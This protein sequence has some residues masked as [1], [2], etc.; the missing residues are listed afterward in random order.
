MS[1]WLPWPVTHTSCLSLSASPHARAGRALPA[2]LC[3]RLS[4]GAT[5]A[6]AIWRQTRSQLTGTLHP[7]IL[8]THRC[9]PP[10]RPPGRAPAYQPALRATG[11]R[12]CPA[13]WPTRAC[14]LVGTGLGCTRTSDGSH[15]GAG[16][17]SLTRLPPSSTCPALWR[18]PR[19]LPVA[20]PRRRP[21][22]R[23]CHVTEPAASPHARSSTHGHTPHDVP[24][25][26]RAV[27]WPRL[28]AAPLASCA[29]TRAT[30]RRRWPCLGPWRPFPRRRIAPPMVL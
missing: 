16:P 17:G 18:P 8:T 20:R 13:A 12:A 14:G 30:G 26:H 7:L 21:G 27:P 9:T 4:G 1:S 3:Y 22:R 11:R 5:Q 10:R 29:G 15:R 6:D 2:A 24:V 25:T 23:R 19:R 28:T